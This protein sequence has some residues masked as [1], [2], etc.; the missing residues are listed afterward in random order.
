MLFVVVDGRRFVEVLLLMVADVTEDDG[1]DDL[2]PRFIMLFRLEI[3]DLMLP[4]L[5]AALDFLLQSA[6]FAT[7][8][9]AGHGPHGDVVFAIHTP[10]MHSVCQ[11]MRTVCPP[12]VSICLSIHRR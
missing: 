5:L 8:A 2:S 11:S 1:D 9:A 12:T 3:K 10:L 6:V 7:T 4:L